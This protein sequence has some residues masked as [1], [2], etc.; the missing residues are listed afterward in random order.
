MSSSTTTAAALI[1]AASPPA[2]SQ[3]LS[4]QVEERTLLGAGSAAELGTLLSTAVTYVH[5]GGGP[6]TVRHL[7][8]H[9]RTTLAKA[10]WSLTAVENLTSDRGCQ[11]RLLVPRMHLAGQDYHRVTVT[12]RPGPTAVTSQIAVTEV[13]ED[14][15]PSTHPPRFSLPGWYPALPEPPPGQRRQAV[16][17]AAN[18]GE[19]TS[20]VIEY[21]DDHLPAHQRTDATRLAAHYRA[22][23]PAAGWVIRNQQTHTERPSSLGGVIGYYHHQISFTG[24]FAGQRATGSVHAW[25]TATAAGQWLAAGLTISIDTPGQEGRAP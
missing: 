11:R 3:W 17:V 10:G 25:D 22:A 2:G 7:I 21:R 16:H 20:Y 23:L 15:L 9:Y 24:V 14:H 12:I 18:H 13:D 1:T 19:P 6:G 8:D 5:R 4:T